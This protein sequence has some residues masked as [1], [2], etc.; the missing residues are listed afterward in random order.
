MAFEWLR[1]AFRTVFGAGRIG[2]LPALPASTG[3]AVP[4]T[5]LGPYDVQ[6]R[7]ETGS[8]F[9]GGYGQTVVLTTDYWTLRQRSAELW[10]TN[11]FARGIIRR[12]VTNEIVTGLNLECTPEEAILGKPEESLADWTETVENRFVL[13]GA[14]P[15]L[16]DQKEQDTFGSLQAN[17]RA[18]ALIAGDV[19]IT[20]RQSQVTG[21]PRVQ[22]T[23]GS[24]IQT[25]WPLPKMRQGSRIV[26]GVELD[27]LDHQ[28]AYWVRQADGTSK[29]LPAY[30]EKTGRRLSW[31]V[32]GCDKRLDQVRGQPLLALVLQSLKEIDRFRDSTQRKAVVLSML[33]MFIK[34]E[35]ALPGSRPL[36]AGHVGAVRADAT[37]V[38]D[39]DGMTRRFNAVEHMP[40]L[41][42][43]ELQVGETP[44]A[45]ST[46]GTVESYG[47]FEAAILQGVA[48]SLE[49]P[50]EILRLS[51]SS[52]YSASQA[53]INELKVYLLKTRTKFGDDVCTPIYKEWLISE[54]LNQRI[55]AP[56]LLE[57]WRDPKQYDTWGAWTSC[58]WNG[59]VKVAI[60]PT[61]LVKGYSA[62]IAEGLITRDRAAR[63]LTGMKFSKVVQQLAREDKMLVDCKKILLE[64][65][66]PTP[67][68]PPKTVKAG[69]PANS[70]PAPVRG[71]LREV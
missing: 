2:A 60:D 45:F 69:G 13:W 47:D 59:V 28:V 5:A 57:A 49:I 36:A 11:L 19:L 33:A 24:A 66:N 3:D 65:T 12:L 38:V 10:Q 64:L 44:Q 34:K 51:F 43:D 27:S 1:S 68:A 67:A 40:G 18:E 29:R 15:V 62:M 52:N 63:E 21:L 39:A 56:G 70:Q 41:S 58:D 55:D 23:P 37:S 26:H 30:G 35:Q 50:P 14:D 17:I 20:L 46:Q 32:Y 9:A 16:C 4:V 54:V 25:P 71:I 53:A 22:L 6:Y 42:L 7:Y 8:K 48:W 61:K 31:L